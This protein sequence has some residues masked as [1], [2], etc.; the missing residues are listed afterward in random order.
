MHN[1]YK[2][3]QKPHKNLSLW[4]GNE[5]GL[6]WNHRFS[7]LLALYI[8]HIYSTSS[9]GQGKTAL[10]AV[11]MQIPYRSL[12]YFIIRA[13]PFFYVVFS[14]AGVLATYNRVKLFSAE[15]LTHWTCGFQRCCREKKNSKPDIY[16]FSHTDRERL[17][18]KK[19][20]IALPVLT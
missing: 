12:Y 19:Q 8:C 16:S 18:G 7:W 6:R 11:E 1:Q 10:G 9:L 3:L 2:N 17:T 5:V 4:I 15:L 14:F 13:W 20:G